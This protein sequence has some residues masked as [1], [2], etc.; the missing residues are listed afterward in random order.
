[1]IHLGVQLS[2]GSRHFLGTNSGTHHQLRSDS[3]CIAST[4]A[5]TYSSVSCAGRIQAFIVASNRSPASSASRT[6][7]ASG[8]LERP[9]SFSWYPPPTSLCTPAN[10]TCR[11]LCPAGGGSPHRFC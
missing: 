6:I 5:A 10:H 7:H 9:L 4:L 11:T 3:C 2:V 8:I 1:M